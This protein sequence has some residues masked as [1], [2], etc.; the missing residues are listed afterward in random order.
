ML[1]MGKLMDIMTDAPQQA[2]QA[3]AQ[4]ESS[5]DK[6][7]E[8]KAQEA[9]TTAS[10]AISFMLMKLDE[11]T[12]AKVQQK[13]LSVC[14]KSANGNTISPVI[15]RDGRLTD[16]ALEYDI[17]TITQLMSQAIHLNLSPFFAK[18]KLMGLATAG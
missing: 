1:L 2:T 13:A 7:D 14:Y 17:D 6:T 12:F 11:D 8:Q 18:G 16:K 3:Q 15:M 10:A 5:E 4:P 9:S